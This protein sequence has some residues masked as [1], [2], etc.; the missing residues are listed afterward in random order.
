MSRN[1]PWVVKGV[2]VIGDHKL[3][4]SFEDGT[5]GDISFEDCEWTGIFEPLRDQRRF[6]KVT[7]QYGTLCW[8]EEGLDWA[9]EP[10]YEQAR[11][12][13]DSQDVGILDFA[14]SRPGSVPKRP[15]ASPSVPK[16]PRS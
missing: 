9:P 12:T 7:L 4:L 5:V 3:R 11:T 2:A 13:C 15:E 14:A 1:P 16:R 8:P 10:L 6:A